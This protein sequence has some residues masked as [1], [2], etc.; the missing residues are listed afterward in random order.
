MSCARGISCKHRHI[1]IK[2]LFASVKESFSIKIN[3]WICLW[4][5]DPRYYN[6]V[7]LCTCWVKD[8]L[9][10]KHNFSNGSVNQKSGA[11]FFYIIRL[12]KLYIVW[13]LIRLE[14]MKVLDRVWL[15]PYNSVSDHFTVQTFYSTANFTTH[16]KVLPN[17]FNEIKFWHQMQSFIKNSLC[18]PLT[19][20]DY[21]NIFMACTFSW[22]I[23]KL[24]NYS[25]NTSTHIYTLKIRDYA[26]VW[27]G[28]FSPH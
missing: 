13:G 23:S 25:H 15:T 4:I 16:Q 20:I 12:E 5:D 1:W 24:E 9:Y 6:P 10:K 28:S 14:L 18:I 8:I 27:K 7:C 17:P 11:D 22:I 19:W 26:C 3:W 2:I 21:L